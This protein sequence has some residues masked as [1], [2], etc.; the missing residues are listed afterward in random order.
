MSKHNKSL[1]TTLANIKPAINH[2]SSLRSTIFWITTVKVSLIGGGVIIL[3][4]PPLSKKSPGMKFL[5][6]YSTS[7]EAQIHSGLRYINDHLICMLFTY[8]S[9]NVFGLKVVVATVVVFSSA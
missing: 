5:F 2:I 9:S 6:K 3:K 8:G 1:V 7:Y 4:F